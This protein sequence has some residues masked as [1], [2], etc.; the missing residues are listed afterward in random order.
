MLFDRPI[1]GQVIGRIPAA[2]VAR[3]SF[4]SS[5]LTSRLGLARAVKAID[6]NLNLIGGRLGL[7]HD[8]VLFGR[9]AIPVMVRYLDRRS[10]RCMR[11]G[12]LPDDAATRLAVWG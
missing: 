6:L 10:G 2:A 1:V 9:F 5:G 11:R 4:T 7:D 8:R 12:A 3:P